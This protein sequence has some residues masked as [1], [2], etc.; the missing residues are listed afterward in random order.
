MIHSLSNLRRRAA[1]L[2]WTFHK[3][4]R[5]KGTCDN[6][7]QYQIVHGSRNAGHVIDGDCYDASLERVA[8]LIER[9]ER[10]SAP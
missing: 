7:G 2:G 3:S 10:R 5:R 8:Q 6:R 1:K 9:E 4:T